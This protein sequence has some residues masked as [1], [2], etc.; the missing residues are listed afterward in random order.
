M[1]IFKH[2]RARLSFIQKYHYRLVFLVAVIWTAIDICY[3][4]V[5]LSSKPVTIDTV[6][7][8]TPAAIYLRCVIVFIMS[9]MMGYL[10]IFKL[11]QVFR[12]Y[13]LIV[14]LFFKTAILLS[15]S[16]IMNFLLHFSY[17]L[18]IMHLTFLH[19]VDRFF[20]NAASFAWLLEHSVGWIVLFLLTQLIIEINEKYSP[21]VFWDILIGRYLQPKV[22]KRIVMFIDLKDSTP[23]AEKL[24][25]KDNFKF[26]RDFIYYI[27]V[28]LMEYDGRIYQSVG[29]E[30]VVSWLYTPQNVHKCI[31]ALA[32]SARLLQRNSNY[33][34]QRYGVVP[35]F[36]AGVHAG[37]VTVGEIG[38]VKKDI[39][40]SGDTMNTAARIRAS[41]ADLDHKY[42]ASKDLL[43]RI[44]LSWSVESLGF[45]DLKGKTD[46]IELFVLNI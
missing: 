22:Q 37:E 20:G 14:N 39:A 3:W 23:I 2:L 33:F 13:P 24:G 19:A 1:T 15:A 25:S 18:C 16:L 45:V 44:D 8:I 38:V 27:S 42:I 43:D 9:C 21:G 7:L 10:L 40:M 36:K 30:I 46:N 26:I 17:S 12:S 4:Y 11:R 41:C 34:S 32:L 6:E 5:D 35:E 28:A 29:D 31:D